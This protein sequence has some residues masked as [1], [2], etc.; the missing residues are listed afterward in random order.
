[1][2]EHRRLKI[3]A[4]KWYA[5]KLAP[6]NMETSNRSSSAWSMRLAATASPERG[7][8]SVGQAAVA[9][10][11]N[12]RPS[13]CSRLRDTRVKRINKAGCELIRS[14]PGSSSRKALGLRQMTDNLD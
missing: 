14:L 10:R 3:D 11:G 12:L 5:S 2:T 13:R 7:I 1:M 9:A 6:K 8:R 4:R